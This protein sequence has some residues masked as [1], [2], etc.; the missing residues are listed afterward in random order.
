MESSS[1]IL[2]SIKDIKQQN[3]PMS[4][5]DFHQPDYASYF[6]VIQEHNYLN[7]FDI[8]NPVFL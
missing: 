5:G 8:T 7:F 6:V 4:W 2:N 1:I 3:A